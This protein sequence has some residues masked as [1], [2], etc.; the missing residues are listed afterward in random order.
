MSTFVPGI[1][2]F[3][4]DIQNFQPDWS[5]V[6][7][8]LRLKQGTYDSNYASLQGTYSGLLNMPQLRKDQIDKR[9]KFLKSAFKTLGDL[10]SV[11]LSLPENISSANN[12]FS[13][14]YNDTEFL[15]NASLSKHYQQQE[16]Y[17]DSLRQ[18]DGGKEFSMDNLNYVRQQKNDYINEQSP[19]AWR[20]YYSN[21]RSYESYYDYY[22]ELGD[23]QKAFKPSVTE[24][25]YVDG[26]YIKKEKNASITANEYSNYLQ[27][28]LSDKARRQLQ[29]EASVK[30][31][32]NIPG[33]TERFL[34]SAYESSK[35]IDK[36]IKTNREAVKLAHT[37][38]EIDQIN[39]NITDLE[40][41]KSEINTNVQRIQSGDDSFIKMNKENLAN[42]FY[43]SDFLARALKGTV[44]TDVTKGIQAN[45]VWTTIYSQNQ[46]NARQARGF[47][48]DKEM[49][50]LDFQYDLKK[51]ELKDGTG[52]TPTF[53]GD[54]LT[55]NSNEVQNFSE[56]SITDLIQNNK[57]S[58]NNASNI[59][60]GHLLSTI[61][62]DVNNNTIKQ[63]IDKNS[64]IQSNTVPIFKAGNIIGY[65]DRS[66]GK[67][68][69]ANEIAD[70]QILKQYQ[71]TVFPLET[72]NQNLAYNKK[73]LDAQA[74]KTSE[75]QV[76]NKELDKIFNG[77]NFNIRQNGKTI[78]LS[79]RQFYDAVNS[80]DIKVAKTPD[81]HIT[82]SDIFTLPWNDR[83]RQG[84]TYNVLGNEVN[85]ADNQ[86]LSSLYSKIKDL[87]AG[88]GR[89]NRVKSSQEAID[90][91]IYSSAVTKNN[92]MSV[93]APKST[94]AKTTLGNIEALT[95]LDQSGIVLRGLVNM[96]GE[97]G[98]TVSDQK[99][100]DALK[101]QIGKI[102]NGVTFD[103]TNNMFIISDLKNTNFLNN[104]NGSEKSMYDFLENNLMGKDMGDGIRLKETLP[105][106]ID[107]RLPYNFII[108]KI[109]KNSINQEGNPIF[110]YDYHIY[111]AS[112][113]NK[114]LFPGQPNKS[115]IET[116]NRLRT[117]GSDPKKL[118]EHI[119]SLK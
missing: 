91:N 72:Y 49:K 105:F 62:S 57:A 36:E 20:N 115:A 4:P 27:A 5:T 68:L 38:E 81:N 116:I 43:Y 26:A 12:V 6:D 82:M 75:Y 18:K 80:G 29:I 41:A 45:S 73:I 96:T 112:N 13:P 87:Q 106:S 44:R 92:V 34:S 61:G 14:L 84:L 97:V 86:V 51:A 35:S 15:G 9:D 66:T 77:R 111:E 10:S 54:A 78:S 101:E 99:K 88:I 2:D 71:T 42:K 74:A 23:L 117:L 7:R 94:F 69:S 119:E 79:P 32:S 113:P 109:S 48:H 103:E 8:T 40:K 55:L 90:K 65:R 104:L 21:K 53:T 39:S 11:D 22:K 83:K 59:I 102:G 46:Q 17:A 56:K 25:E 19:D 98:F 107:N 31:G 58:I 114:S 100:A 67:N 76:V 30:L 24:V 52:G 60:K 93:L 110:D 70:L 64:K 16:Q 47:E 28:N 37:Q 118:I 89:N 3:I 33:L 95:G 50:A 1:T 108:K 63:F 85:A